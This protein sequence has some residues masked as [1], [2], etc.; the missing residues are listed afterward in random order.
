MKKS[1]NLRVIMQ[2]KQIIISGKKGEELMHFFDETCQMVDDEDEQWM[3][4]ALF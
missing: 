2:D 4:E 1:D 3:S